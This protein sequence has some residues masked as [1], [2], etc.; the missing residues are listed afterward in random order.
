[1]VDVYC[2]VWDLAATRVLVPEAGGR[3]E[4][5]DHGDGKAGLI[6][7]NPTLVETLLEFWDAAD[8]PR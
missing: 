7:G 5:L 2:N 1:M 6:F 4:T 3:C 8:L